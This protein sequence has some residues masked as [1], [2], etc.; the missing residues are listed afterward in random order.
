MDQVPW[1]GEPSRKGS[2]RYCSGQKCTTKINK[3][4]GIKIIFNIN[5]NK[6]II[7]IIILIRNNI[8]FS[9]T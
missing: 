9:T 2:L 1:P 3:L 8:K 4:N 5:Y 7:I 6:E